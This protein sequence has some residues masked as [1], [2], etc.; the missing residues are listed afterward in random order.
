[1]EMKCIVPVVMAR[2]VMHPFFTG[3]TVDI[4]GDAGVR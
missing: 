1:M 3:M 2:V 4:I